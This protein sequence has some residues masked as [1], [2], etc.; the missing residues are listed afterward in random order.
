MF[1][2]GFKS[3]FA[4]WGSDEDVELASIIEAAE[5]E[6]Q[7]ATEFLHSKAC[8]KMLEDVKSEALMQEGRLDANDFKRS[9]PR[10]PL[11]K[12]NYSSALVA[13]SK[14]PLLGRGVG[15]VLQVRDGSSLRSMSPVHFEATGES[16]QLVM[17]VSNPIVVP[18]KLGTASMD[19]L[20]RMAAAGMK[21][22]AAQAIMAMP[23][24][25]ITGK[26]LDL[27]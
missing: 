13:A 11:D 3:N 7:K 22:M 23:L 16:G 10:R 27:G 21:G 8:A 4:G 12:K 26:T 1:A 14:A 24:E 19:I 15:A 17:Q 20:Q 25:D 6:L 9:P 18:S 2:K 5:V